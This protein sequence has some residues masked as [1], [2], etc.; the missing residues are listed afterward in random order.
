MFCCRVLRGERCHGATDYLDHDY[1]NDGI[2]DTLEAE[3]IGQNQQT[4]TVTI[5]QGAKVGVD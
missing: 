5:P 3:V 2:P 4:S 1:D